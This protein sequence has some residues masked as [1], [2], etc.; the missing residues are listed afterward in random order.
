MSGLD[1]KEAI[2]KI[3]KIAQSE[4]YIP[5]IRQR[6]FD[7]LSTVEDDD[8]DAVLEEVVQEYKKAKDYN[9]KRNLQIISPLIAST[10]KDWGSE[11]NESEEEPKKKIKKWVI[12]LVA[13]S[14]KKWE[15]KVY[16]YSVVHWGTPTA[17]RKVYKNQMWWSSEWL[18]ITNEKWVAYPEEK[19]FSAWDVVYIKAPIDRLEKL[20]EDTK[21][22]IRLQENYIDN[23]TESRKETLEEFNKQH[24][25]WRDVEISFWIPVKEY[26]DID[27]TLAS[28]TTNQTLDPKKYEVVILLNRPNKD[29]EF[30]KKTEEK[31]L[32]FK[33]NHPE[34]NIH[35]FKHTFSFPWGKDAEVNMWEIYKLLWDTIIHRNTQRKNIKWMDMK[36]IRNLIVKRGASDST[37]KHPDYLKHQIECYSHDYWGKE[38]VRLAWESRILKDVALTYPLLEIDEFFQRYYDLEYQHGNYLNR[39][40]WL[41]SCKARCYCGVW[42]TP[43]VRT[44]EDTSFVRKIRNYVEANKDE[45]CMYYDKDFIWATDGSTDR[46][47]YSIYKWVPYCQKYK[48]ARFDGADRTK[49]IEWNS[50][51]I[52]NKWNS[53]TKGLELTTK[54]L[55]RDLWALYRQ[56][57]YKIFDPKNKIL[58]KDYKKY[59][60]SSDWKTATEAEKKI[61][62]AKNIVSPIFEKILQ[63]PDFMGLD[64][65]DYSIEIQTSWYVRV[66]FNE[67]SIW[68]IL[69]AQEQRKEAGYYDYFK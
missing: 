7:V 26:E 41:W 18:L 16:R 36:K 62:I 59:L 25:M 23:Q 63:R 31:I 12:K 8:Q 42:G 48:E 35:L 49:K 29:V 28:I 57:I 38:L 44:S 20:D 10:K 11:E 22:K 6:V 24:P 69:A 43:T 65:S 64:K 53:K 68:K 32:K 1:T 33:L 30:D 19:R 56:R 9:T 37:E 39:D 40:V 47:I 2:D 60:N 15:Y 66:H 3:K 58:N 51:A 67:S 50:W 52:E 17:I 14:D 13:N 54:N 45:C 4:T 21:E 34:Y 27:K 55:E 61:R 46:W 5:E